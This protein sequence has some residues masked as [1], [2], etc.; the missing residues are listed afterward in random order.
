MNKLGT[1]LMLV[2][3]AFALA[4]PGCASNVA[5]DNETAAETSERL[6]PATKGRNA[7]PSQGQSLGGPPSIVAVTRTEA[8]ASAV[9]QNGGDPR[10]VVESKDDL[11]D[12]PIGNGSTEKKWCSASMNG[13]T[14]AI[15]CETDQGTK[16][17]GQCQAG[18]EPSTGC[19][20]NQLIHFCCGGYFN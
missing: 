6:S 1:S 4:L 14:G 20:N 2:G 11:G 8:E 17:Y 10:L 18:A 3:I 16:T 5:P 15:T 9:T 13:Q 19:T 12:D 7:A